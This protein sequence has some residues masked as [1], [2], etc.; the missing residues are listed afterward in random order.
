MILAGVAALLLIPN[1]ASGATYQNILTPFLQS[2]ELFR[3]HPYWDVSRYSWGYGTKAPG[4]TGTITEAQAMQDLLSH[5]QQ[6]YD[7]LKQLIDVDLNANQWAALLSFSYN[8]G[9]ANADNLITNINNQDWQAL[10]DQWKQYI[11]VNGQPSSNLIARRA[12][13][14]ELFTR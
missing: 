12:A 6:D 8:L 4:P 11:N 1:M 3:A 10:E 7:Y 13:E 2:W 9:P 5:V 14:W